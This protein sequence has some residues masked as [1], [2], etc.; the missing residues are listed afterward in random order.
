MSEYQEIEGQCST[1]RFAAE[2]G[3]SSGPSGPEDG[4]HCTSEANAISMNAL[5]E[6]REY[7]F[8]D[9]FRLECIAE[10]TFR[11]PHWMERKK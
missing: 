1:C 11:C 3:Y 2:F 9:L 4:V 8:L 7:G 10:D 5:P 6:F